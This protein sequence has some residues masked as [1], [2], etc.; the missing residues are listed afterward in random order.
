MNNPILTLVRGEP[1]KSEEI[2]VSRSAEASE[3]IQV[4][5]RRAKAIKC[6]T[7]TKDQSKA[8][9]VA[10]ELQGLR[11]GLRANY[12]ATKDPIVSLGRAI[13]RLFHDIDDPLLAEYNRI[14]GTVSRFQDDQ[15]RESERA[16]AKKD[17]EKKA[18]EEAAAQKIREL[19]K[20]KEKLELK[21]RLAEDLLEKRRAERE[22]EKKN[23]AIEG[24]KIGLEIE[25]DSAVEQPI[26]TR[27]AP[28][29]GRTWIEYKVTITDE[30]IVY[31]TRREFLKVELR[32]AAAQMLA[33]SLDEAG[34]SLD[35]PGLKIE[36][37][38]RTSFAGAATI[39]IEG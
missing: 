23:V 2:T 24:Q 38:T 26:A 39:R 13:D 9:L 25:R 35:V 37:I 31:D 19:E 33:K 14:A 4:V 27:S 3:A 16:E 15:R 18:V 11:S 21:A 32:T 1:L 28:P 36:K 6:I 20:E 5:I 10:S 29:G 12:R 8:A 22:I 30:R 34:K 7:D 17:A